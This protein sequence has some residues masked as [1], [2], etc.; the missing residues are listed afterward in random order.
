MIEWDWETKHKI[1]LSYRLIHCLPCR[2]AKLLMGLQPALP[3]ALTL[4][5]H[6][7]VPRLL[8]SRKKRFSLMQTCWSR[9]RHGRWTRATGWRPS[10]PWVTGSQPPSPWPSDPTSPSLCPLRPSRPSLRRPPTAMSISNY[11]TPFTSHKRKK[12]IKKRW[13]TS[14]TIPGI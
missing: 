1:I 10:W 14:W 2:G 4:R 7:R 6:R 12:L 9:N 13:N 5:R 11:S 8:P 3:P